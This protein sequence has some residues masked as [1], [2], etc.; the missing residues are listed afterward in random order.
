M[1]REFVPVKNNK[2][3]STDTYFAGQ[4]S[5]KDFAIFNCLD[6]CVCVYVRFSVRAIYVFEMLQWDLLLYIS[7][8]SHRVTVTMCR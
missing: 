8:R 4:R 6:D 5:E 1:L 3:I 7:I 2:P